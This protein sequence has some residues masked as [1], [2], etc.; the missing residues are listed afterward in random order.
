MRTPAAF[1][2]PADP[3]PAAPSFSDVPAEHWAAMALQA[4]AQLGI[5]TGYPDGTFGGK[6]AVTRYEGAIALQRLQQQAQRNLDALEERLRALERRPGPGAA[7]AAPAASGAAV[8]RVRLE[9]EQLSREV[10][11]LQ[12][13]YAGLLERQAAIRRDVDDLRERLGTT[14]P[15][16]P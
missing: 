16:K 5:F 4:L 12:R 14:E 15:A 11:E 6:R 2:Q 3:A 7:P 10:S 8:E 1:A 13:I 9:T